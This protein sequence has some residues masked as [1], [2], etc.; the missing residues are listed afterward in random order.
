MNQRQ[1]ERYENRN[2]I[3]RFLTYTESIVVRNKWFSFTL[4][5]LTSLV[6]AWLNLELKSSLAGSLAFLGF[7][8]PMTVFTGRALFKEENVALRLT[9]GFATLLAIIAFFGTLTYLAIDYSWPPMLALLVALTLSLSFLNRRTKQHLEYSAENESKHGLEIGDWKG[10]AKDVA[11]ILFI[12]LSLHAIYVGRTDESIR[13]FWEVVNS[14]TFFLPYF[15]ASS[16]AVLTVLSRK[17]STTRILSY[18]VLLT[19]VAALIPI[20]TL[21][22]PQTH[23]MGANI[24]W[25]RHFDEFGRFVSE[26]EL[27]E[28]ASGP[29]HK[30]LEFTGYNVIMVTL[31]RLLGT[32]PALFNVLLTPILF[33]F[34]APIS[35]YILIKIVFPN[36]PKVALMSALALLISQHN[37]YLLV[38]AGKPETLGLLFLLLSIVFWTRYLVRKEKAL[39]SSTF[40]PLLFSIAAVLSH[41]NV[42]VFALALVMISIYIRVA[43]P[44]ETS[45]RRFGYDLLGK[46]GYILLTV[47][48]PLSLIIAYQTSNFLGFTRYSLTPIFDVGEWTKVL[49]PPFESL[50]VFS[51]E[52]LRDLYLNNFTYIWYALV[53]GGIFLSRRWDANPK[54]LWLIIPLISMSFASMILQQ[55]FFPTF[56]AREYYRFFYYLNFITYPLVGFSLY[57]ITRALSARI[58]VRIKAK[59]TRIFERKLR[60]VLSWKSCLRSGT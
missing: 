16:I 51:F 9:F 17:T 41:P 29:I 49:F 26:P 59:K 13:T 42:G 20:I 5:S 60:N 37:I 4:L 31:S 38:P 45:D 21:E 34:Y 46:F 30:H 53:L 39:F 35:A 15:G 12:L 57:A 43:K 6:V 10:Y 1:S 25:T 36:R 56:W 19:L 28:R 32:D 50:Q 8:I 47:V 23:M 24:A 40:T 18:V 55:F 3:L 27:I 33:A 11:F 58:S 2:M 54:L 14:A 48:L 7:L 44:F 22:H 52:G